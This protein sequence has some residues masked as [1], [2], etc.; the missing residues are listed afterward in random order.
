MDSMGSGTVF[1]TGTNSGFGRATVERF[2]DRG[3][4]VAA[5][6][7]RTEEFAD[8]FGG[9]GNVRVYGLDVTDPDA[10]ASVAGRAIGDFGGVDVLVNNAGYFQMG[11]L[12]TSTMEQIRAQFE[13]NVFGLI[14]LTKAFLPHF[15]AN[16]AGTI[17]NVSSVSAENGYPF[18]SAYSASKAAVAALTEALNVELDAVGVTAKAVL[19]G[20][21][22]TKI[23]TKV[24]VAPSVPAAYR[25]LLEGFV[26]QQSSVKGSRPEV[27]AEAIWEAATDGRRDKVRYYAGPDAT[28]VPALK[29]LM[30][31]ER[32]FRFFRNTLL[33]GP[34]PLLRR[35]APQGDAEVEV[36]LGALKA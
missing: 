18:A 8:I 19:P 27:V 22:A 32:Y 13:T 33:R 7:R 34:N 9:R 25:P 36:D 21:H 24:D 28:V 10:V 3:W 14:A 5:T 4:N 26:S 29:R 6:M 23:F 16:G 11:P 1:V 15:R 12:E 2:A 17:V 35:F 31:Q 20:Q 30:G